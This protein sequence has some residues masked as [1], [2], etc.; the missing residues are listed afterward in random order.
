MFM[1]NECDKY[2]NKCLENTFVILD[3]EYKKMKKD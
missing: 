1:N 2:K 3:V